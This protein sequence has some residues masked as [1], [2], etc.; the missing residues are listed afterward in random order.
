MMRF[1]YELVCSLE[2]TWLMQG[3]QPSAHTLMAAS[4][5]R[6]RALGLYR[7]IL[8]LHRHVLPPEMRAMGDAYV[9]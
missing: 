4:E 6:S 7:R 3:K 1:W 8:R 2:G 5:G 9:Q